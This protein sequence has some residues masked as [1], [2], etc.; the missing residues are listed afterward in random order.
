MVFEL[1]QDLDDLVAT[2]PLTHPKRRVLALLKEAIRRDIHFIARHPTTL[3]QC[4]WNTCWWH[5]CPDAAAHYEEPDGGWPATGP[6]APPW[7]RPGARLHTLLE[8]WRQRRGRTP[9]FRYHRPV[10]PPIGASV[11]R[12]SIPDLIKAIDIAPDGHTIAVAGG[13][14]VVYLGDI[15]TFES[16]A[17]LSLHED[18][19][20]SVCFSP[21]KQYVA[22]GGWDNSACI[23]NTRSRRLTQR[24]QFEDWVTATRFPP[25]RSDV[26]VLGSGETIHVCERGTGSSAR[27][28]QGHTQG[29]TSLRF[30]AD[31]TRLLSASEDH[32]VCIW[33][34]V[35][36]AL[37]RRLVGHEHFV[38]DAA[39]AHADEDL[40]VSGGADHTVR[41]WH[42]QD[43]EMHSIE[44][45]SAVERVAFSAGDRE[46]I[47]CLTNSDVHVVDA[48]SHDTLQVFPHHSI[49]VEA[50]AV[51]PNCEFVASGDLHG[52]ICLWTPGR[53]RTLVPRGHVRSTHHV[54]AVTFA[55][56]GHEAASTAWHGE[57]CTWDVAAGTPK[58][59]ITGLH[60]Y[61]DDV[62]Y[63]PEGK[64]LAV[65]ERNGIIRLVD[66]VSG[67]MRCLTPET[68]E[69]VMQYLR[70]NANGQYLIRYGN[71]SACRVW[72]LESQQ[73]CM[74]LPY[75]SCSISPTGARLAAWCS[76]EKQ[77]TPDRSHYGP[78][79]RD[80]V[81]VWDA[82][83]MTHLFDLADDGCELRGVRFSSDEN[84]LATYGEDGTIRL[85]D[86]DSGELIVAL[87]GHTRTVTH[88]V[89]N[90]DSQLLASY[91]WDGT[92]RIWDVRR[93]RCK[94][95]LQPP[96]RTYVRLSFSP[97]S[98]QL[99]FASS[100]RSEHALWDVGTGRPI[101]CTKDF[102]MRWVIG[103]PELSGLGLL[104]NR[105]ETILTRGDRRI[106]A[107]P[108]R[109]GSRSSSVATWGACEGH[110][111]QF[112]SLEGFPLR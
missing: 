81:H 104:R 19:A 108:L 106:A 76:L 67:E 99:L 74:C 96:K 44:L 60:E 70:F 7:N 109:L 36:G 37:L 88:V 5:D 20:V 112:A 56:G 59:A 21:D 42:L 41:L 94:H 23:W 46:L 3:F 15:R 93:R 51:S 105:W 95:I 84:C 58:L 52:N 91:S 16:I 55:P 50:L 18:S 25:G 48:E 45:P 103:H 2:L 97:D 89:F 10:D 26:L 68:A 34:F 29:I 83:E 82:T 31:G 102:E 53:T 73:E 22:S 27:T 9:W 78:V 77:W 100:D 1:A 107:A 87:K 61:L 101:G 98:T 86:A 65:S 33:D 47:A 12:L 111:V 54:R 39:F 57:L 64:L 63:H 38:H 13:S 8:H 85:R 24:L 75:R 6:H 69:D 4:M 11:R 80:V 62:A 49:S 28:L 71:G 90:G 66:T 79:E 40:V 30:N 110:H 32:T 35:S 43:R 17:E 72:D 92:L 14:G